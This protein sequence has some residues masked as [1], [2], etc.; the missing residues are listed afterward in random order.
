MKRLLLLSFLI[1]FSCTKVDEFSSMD[2]VSE[3]IILKASCEDVGSETKT[4]RQSD[5]AVHW[6]PGD[7]ISLFFNRGEGGGSKF[8]SQNEEVGSVAEFVGTING[9]SA[10][11][12]S[13]GGG[14]YFWGVYPY[15]SVNSCDG[16]TVT[17]E[18][19][20]VQVAMKGSFA[21]GAFPTVGR[22]KGLEMSFY[23]VCGGIKFCLMNEGIKSVTFRANNNE[24]IAGKVKVGFDENG[25]PAVTEVID[26][27]DEIVINAPNGGTFETGEDVFYYITVLPQQMA[28]GFTMTFHK[29]DQEADYV[30]ESSV[31][32][33]RSIFGVLREPD[34]NITEWT[35]GAEGSGDSNGSVLPE[36]PSGGKEEGLYLGIMAFNNNLYRFPVTRV[37]GQNLNKFYSFID[38]MTLINQTIL[39]WAVDRAF[40]DL[41]SPVYP[42]D[43]YNASILTFTDGLERGSLGLA[44]WAYE[45]SED[46]LSAINS[47]FLSENVSGQKVT[48]YSVGVRGNDVKTTDEYNRFKNQL[49][50][51]ATPG[52]DYEVNSMSELDAQFQEIADELSETFDVQKITLADITVGQAPVLR[53]RFTLDNVTDVNNSRKYIEG[54]IDFRTGV[55]S[56]IEYYGLTSTSGD[57][58]V[59]TPGVSGLTDTFIFDFEG[60]RT[61][62]GKLIDKTDITHWEWLGSYWQRNSEYEPDKSAEVV[63]EKKSATIMLV[64]DNSS[65]LG[66][67]LLI[68]QKAAKSFISKVYNASIDPLAVA[69]VS[70]N[71]SA[72]ELNVGK[73]ETLNATVL[74][75]TAADTKLIWSSNDTSVATVDANGK[76]TALSPGEALIYA[77]SVNGGKQAVCRVNVVQLAETVSLSSEALELYTGKSQK[78]TATVLPENTTDSS[79]KWSV[80]DPSVASVDDKG[81]VTALKAGSTVMTVSTMDGSSRKASCTITVKQHVNDIVLDTESLCIALDEKVILSATISPSDASDKSISWRSSDES[82][83]VVNAEGEVTGVGKGEAVVTAE[84]VDGGLVATC[85]VTVISYVK[86]LYLDKTSIDFYSGENV[87]LTATVVPADASD[88]SVVWKSNDPS[89]AEVSDDGVVTAVSP[90]ATIVTASTKDGTD[91]I[92]YCQ[93][94]VRMDVTGVSLEQQSVILPR[95]SSKVLIAN[96]FPENATETGL[97]WK[98]SDESVLKVNDGGVITGVTMGSAV[99]TVTTKDGG[100]TESCEVEVGMSVTFED[101]AL[102]VSKDGQRYYVNKN[103]YASLDLSEYTEDGLSIKSNGNGF[104]LLLGDYYMKGSEVMTKLSVT[105]HRPGMILPSVQISGSSDVVTFTFRDANELGDLPDKSQAETIV[106]R[107]SEI[108]ENLIYYGGS[109]ILEDASYWTAYSDT[110]F[111]LYSKL[112]VSFSTNP[113]SKYRVRGIIVP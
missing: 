53:T 13:F 52:K 40:D 32:I 112:C 22:S 76:I 8:V 27:S 24:T 111:Y 17:M 89:I 38:A 42:D 20:P 5:G 25:R 39:C 90:G 91:I 18:L 82:V 68:L 83:A 73:S 29:E 54:V 7:A 107:F 81:N 108:N 67:S 75:S 69:S 26:G 100:F 99:V 95:N 56:E 2:A 1:L 16:T 97:I 93:V 87:S 101:M 106:S 88:A 98:S 80:S 61:S 15:A 65:S 47:R 34:K 94:L 35:D 30:R 21:S 23:N 92:A 48:A 79:L 55:F 10:G 102:A 11:G 41:K 57:V 33:K 51:L 31:T 104:I 78:L 60:L 71:K 86:E 9:I 66:E 59:G 62:D 77:T 4:I 37:T 64:L 85:D 63:T 12:E 113:E 36:G 43:L 6:C 110:F 84:T 3:T 50:M 70:L 49:K 105:P 28:R 46:Y 14:S 19:S 44:D 72:V 103:E 45:T 96:V 58:I 109:A 74:P